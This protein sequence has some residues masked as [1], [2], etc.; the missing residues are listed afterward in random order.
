MEKVLLV[1]DMVNGYLYG[2]RPLVSKERRRTLINNIKRTINLAHKRHIPVI[3]V[4]SAFEKSSPM[5]K[6]IGYYPQPMK[7]T[8][9]AQLIPA[10]KPGSKD[11]IVE[12][13]TYDGFWRSDLQKLLKKLKVKDVYL[14]GQQ[15]D[16]CIRE[17]GVTAAQLGYKVYIIKDCCDSAREEGVAHN[18]AIRFMST[19]VGEI[20]DSKKLNW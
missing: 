11:R 4:N 17:T 20:V 13:T 12:K 15:T 5:L 18:S 19:C 7:G 1:M 8:K 16:C 6:V 9:E 2:P 3:Y 10:L 14:A